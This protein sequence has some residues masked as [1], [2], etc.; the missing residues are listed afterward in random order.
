MGPQTG[1]TEKSQSSV[2]HYRIEYA[3][4]TPSKIKTLWSYCHR[5]GLSIQDS[6]GQLSGVRL[7]DVMLMPHFVQKYGQ[8]TSLL[9]CL[10]QCRMQF[11][12][13]SL[14]D[15]CSMKGDR[16]LEVAYE[17]TQECPGIRQLEWP[18][19]APSLSQHHW[20]DWKR[21]WMNASSNPTPE[22]NFC[23]NP[24]DLVLG[25]QLGKL[26]PQLTPKSC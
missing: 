9:Q 15:L 26:V 23:T 21:H 19:N 10:N 13:V 18:R 1:V 25:T 20:T 22:T 6:F 7:N 4:T 14:G 3:L 8:D 2:S 12:A 17:G 16:M 5:F 24:W 11:H